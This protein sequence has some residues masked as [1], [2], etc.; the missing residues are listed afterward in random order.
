MSLT[1]MEEMAQKA[2]TVEQVSSY[3]IK[4]L[5]TVSP[6]KLQKLLYYT[7]AFYYTF[8]DKHIHNNVPVDFE[9]WAHGPV[10]PHLYNMYKDDYRLHDSIEFNECMNY[11]KL[12][13]ID[14]EFIC[15]V[16]ALLGDKS[17]P[18]LETFSHTEEPWLEKRGD[19]PEF[20]PSRAVISY[21]TIK[22]YYKDKLSM[23]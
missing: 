4:S 10:N 16:L 21:D 23:R 14:K 2:D 22:S 19:L 18:F 12:N 13:K 7:C 20:A 17:G 5:Q 9:A 3:I 8:E 6:L 15:S 11:S 1:N